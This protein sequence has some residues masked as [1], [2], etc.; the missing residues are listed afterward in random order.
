MNRNP[1]A[2]LDNNL[3]LYIRPRKKYLVHLFVSQLQ[4]VHK[5][6][7]KNNSKKYFLKRKTQ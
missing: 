4:T 5:E 7:E 6:R 1:D 2:S 3:N